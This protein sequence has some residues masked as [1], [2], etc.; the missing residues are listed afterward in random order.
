M[1]YVEYGSIVNGEFV[2]ACGDRA[3]VILDG[4]N[5]I[6]TMDADAIAYNGNRRPWYQAYR[7]CKGES[8]TRSKPVGDYVL[9]PKQDDPARSKEALEKIKTH[10]YCAAQQ[11]DEFAELSMDAQ[12]EVLLKVVGWF[13]D[14]VMNEIREGE[15]NDGE[16]D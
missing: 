5:S 8:F 6:Q 12:G 11:I 15:V 9:L 10:L 1:Y 7:I 3:V 13:I 16:T 14:G 4:R 2:A